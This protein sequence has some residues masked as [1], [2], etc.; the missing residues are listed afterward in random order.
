MRPQS[1]LIRREL[2]AAGQRI[3]SIVDVHDRKQ[4]MT[5]MRRAM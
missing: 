2:G 5:S 3:D 1:L 4:I